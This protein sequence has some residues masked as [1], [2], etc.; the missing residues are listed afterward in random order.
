MQRSWCKNATETRG[1]WRLFK[2]GFRFLAKRPGFPG[3]R[4]FQNPGFNHYLK[5]QLEESSAQL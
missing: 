4:V 1:F 3:P 5:A 2:A